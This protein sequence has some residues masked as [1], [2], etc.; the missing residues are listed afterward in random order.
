MKRSEPPEVTFE[1]VRI[2]GPEAEALAAEQARVIDEVLLWIATHP[3][4][5]VTSGAADPRGE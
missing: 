4:N 3:Q 2:T 5:D 1:I